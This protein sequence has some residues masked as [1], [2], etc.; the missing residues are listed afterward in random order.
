MA[1]RNHHHHYDHACRNQT[2]TRSKSS[3]LDALFYLAMAFFIVKSTGIICIVGIGIGFGLTTWIIYKI[4]HRRKQK[5]N[6]TETESRKTGRD[7]M[8]T[9]TSQ[10][11]QPKD[12]ISDS[13]DNDSHAETTT[14]FKV[15]MAMQL[16]E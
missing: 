16:N 14:K 15:S 12:K 9:A 7:H 1:V 13:E 8:T 10:A 2:T 5:F 6:K 3:L 4:Y 11:Y